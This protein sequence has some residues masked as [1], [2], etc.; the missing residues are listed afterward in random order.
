M[1]KEVKELIEVIKVFNIEHSHHPYYLYTL[2][3]KDV[4][5]LLD[6]INQLEDKLNKINTIV[7]NIDDKKIPK[8]Q[9][10]VRDI[11]FCLEYDFWANQKVKCDREMSPEELEIHNILLEK[12]KKE[13]SFNE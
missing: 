1:N 8:Y 10:K 3:K 4:E 13:G 7:S 12:I 6:Y 11:K 2:D 9:D 5:L